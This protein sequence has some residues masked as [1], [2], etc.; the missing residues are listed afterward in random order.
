MSFRVVSIAAL[1]LAMYPSIAA[2]APVPTLSPGQQ[3]YHQT[4]SQ[5][6]PELTAADTQNAQLTCQ[7]LRSGVP[8]VLYR[9]GVDGYLSRGD[10]SAALLELAITRVAID[11]FC[12]EYRDQFVQAFN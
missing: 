5:P 6:L 9:A 12:P 7:S 1:S 2:A 8:V 11:R 3:L 10:R 4:A